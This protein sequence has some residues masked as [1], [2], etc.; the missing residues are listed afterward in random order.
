MERIDIHTNFTGTRPE[1]HTLRLV[2][3]DMPRSREILHTLF[4]APPSRKQK[5]KEP[6]SRKE[7]RTLS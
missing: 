3:L 5:V 1:I 2:E 4:F 6:R 7:G